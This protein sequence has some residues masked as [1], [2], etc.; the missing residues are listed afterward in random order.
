MNLNLQMEENGLRK[1]K[2]LRGYFKSGPGSYHLMPFNGFS[3]QFE[4]VG[5]GKEKRITFRDVVINMATGD[6]TTDAFSIENGQLT[7]GPIYLREG[8]ESMR[9]RGLGLLK[10]IFKPLQITSCRIWSLCY[11]IFKPRRVFLCS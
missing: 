7:L 1:T 11:Y 6:V 10:S 2:L 3:G 8:E 4:Q 5:N 9:I